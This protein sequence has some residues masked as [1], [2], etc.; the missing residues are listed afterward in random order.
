M[1]P[2]IM[3]KLTIIIILIFTS[4]SVLQQKRTTNSIEKEVFEIDNNLMRYDLQQLNFNTNAEKKLY[5]KICYPNE[6]IDDCPSFNGTINLYTKRSKIV[7]IVL[8]RQY[9]LDGR[10]KIE[11]YFKNSTPIF[12]IEKYFIPETSGFYQGIRREKDTNKKTYEIFELKAPAKNIEE[13][14]YVLDWNKN[15]I[16]VLHKNDIWIYKHTFSKDRY[17]TIIEEVEQLIE[18]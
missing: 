10:N 16:E 12:I 14:I 5:Y 4:C 3:K 7:K 2:V 18:Q 1:L 13:H 8:Q 15:N 17:I 9:D 6:L 11:I